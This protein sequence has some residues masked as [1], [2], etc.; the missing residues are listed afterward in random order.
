MKFFTA[1]YLFYVFKVAPSTIDHNSK[2]FWRKSVDLLN[3]KR[4]NSDSGFYLWKLGKVYIRDP[5]SEPMRSHWTVSKRHPFC[6][7]IAPLSK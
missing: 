6:F 7:L 1:I 5:H 4:A 3:R 2:K